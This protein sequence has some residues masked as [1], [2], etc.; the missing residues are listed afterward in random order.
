MELASDLN[1]QEFD[2]AVNPDSRLVVQFFSKPVQ[3]NF[4]SE[5]QGRPIFE[6]VD[7]VK[8]YV[9]GDATSVTITPA[10]AD[11]KKRFPLHWAHYQN[12]HAGDAREIGTPIAQW[13]RVSAAQAEELRAVKFFTVESIA[14]A[15]D[16]Q[17]QGLGMVAGMSPFAFRDHAIRFLQ[18]ASDDKKVREL[19]D[20]KSK[21][22]NELAET[23]KE[24][25]E[26][27]AMMEALTK[28]V[29]VG[30]NDPEAGR[31]KGGR[32]PKVDRG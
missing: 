21:M 2:G 11:H 16:S 30:E 9:P 15:S 1:N 26:M 23:R 4:E 29:K 31:N 10:R 24:M 25:A 17:L 20:A 18:I 32:P 28:P 13:P 8:I 12:Q 27:R 3:N 22:E 6:D 19:E 7:F 14:H 5:K